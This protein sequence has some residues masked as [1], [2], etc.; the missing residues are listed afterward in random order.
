MFKV[1]CILSSL[2]IVACHAVDIRES[3]SYQYQQKTISKDVWRAID[4]GVTD[5]QWL[6]QHIGPP[7][8]IVKNDD[9]QIYMYR[10]EELYKKNNSVFLVYQ[11][12]QTAITQKVHSIVLKDG[13]VVSHSDVTPLPVVAASESTSSE[14]QKITEVNHVDAQT[15]AMPAAATLEAP[16]AEAPVATSSVEVPEVLSRDL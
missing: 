10:Y 11:K 13:L 4:V 5:T 2:F 15:T 7:S 16:T 8:S 3:L 12:Q 6:L 1:F 14:Q 9:R